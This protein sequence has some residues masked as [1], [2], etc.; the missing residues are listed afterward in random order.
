MSSSG[1]KSGP[2]DST[3]ER[4]FRAVLGGY[5]SRSETN[6]FLHHVEEFGRDDEEPE[7]F[8]SF[9]SP[10]DSGFTSMLREYG[11]MACAD[12]DP[13]GVQSD[14][15]PNR[16]DGGPAAALRSRGKGVALPEILSLLH[17]RSSGSKLGRRKRGTA[18]LA[19]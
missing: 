13:S 5:E 16:R 14:T 18:V 6:G 7:Y 15:V 8:N 4:N 2:T 12:L 1:A 11:N 9:Q 10:L 17:S 19:R 3:G